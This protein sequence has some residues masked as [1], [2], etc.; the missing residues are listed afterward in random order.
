MRMWLRREVQTRYFAC[1]LVY[2]P[3]RVLGSS[4]RSRH[5]CHLRN[6]RARD[7]RAAGHWLGCVQEEPVNRHRTVDR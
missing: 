2:L 1:P 6:V 7:D 5:G 3:I 4:E